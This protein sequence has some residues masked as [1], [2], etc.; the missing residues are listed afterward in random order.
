MAEPTMRSAPGG[1]SASAADLP[2]A[3]P[4]FGRAEQ[5]VHWSTAALL[6]IVIATASAL[7]VAPI[8]QLIGQRLIVSTIHEWAGLLLAV[9]TLIGLVSARVRARLRQLDRFTAEDEQ[10]VADARARVF[11]A[12]RPGSF[13]AG[14]KLYA[15]LM[16]GGILVALGTG[17]LI[18]FR[19][20][21]TFIPREG[22]VFVHDVTAY[23]VFAALVIHVAKAVGARR[24]GAARAG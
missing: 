15:A 17:L 18:W 10:W 19:F 5:A 16:A 11:A 8:A 13:S 6:V 22:V 7:Y 4:R 2:P 9:P 21:L 3:R 24:S 1:A 20:S 23:A 14:Q 12:P